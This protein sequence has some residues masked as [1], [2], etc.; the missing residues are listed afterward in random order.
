MDKTISSN[1]KN[2]AIALTNQNDAAVNVSFFYTGINHAN[3]VVYSMIASEYKRYADEKISQIKLSHKKI[4]FNI[5]DAWSTDYRVHV[6]K[7]GDLGVNPHYFG[8][9]SYISH[10]KDMV[11]IIALVLV[12]KCLD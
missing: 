5:V 7:I 1:F 8:K 3:K 12:C 9:I 4:S 11:I 2:R 6:F 10:S